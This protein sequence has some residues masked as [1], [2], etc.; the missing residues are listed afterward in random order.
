MVESVASKTVLDPHPA[1]TTG[2]G[3]IGVD[4]FVVTV[5]FVYLRIPICDVVPKLLAIFLKYIGEVIVGNN[6]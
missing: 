6:V 3:I 4:D 1:A 5:F 2:A